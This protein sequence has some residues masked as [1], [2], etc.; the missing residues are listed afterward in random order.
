MSYF[1]DDLFG[2]TTTGQDLKRE[3]MERASAGASDE[4]K[5]AMLDCIRITAI[6][7]PKFTADDVFDLADERKVSPHTENRAFGPVMM[8]AAKM[9]YC[10]KVQAFPDTQLSRRA[11]LH[12]SPIQIW[13]SLLCEEEFP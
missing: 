10:R 2:S 6:A 3:G 8:R 7:M 12:A 13:E 9:K 4:W 5:E 1:D 11:K